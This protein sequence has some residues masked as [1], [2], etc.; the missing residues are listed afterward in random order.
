MVISFKVCWVRQCIN[1][2]FDYN[3]ELYMYQI[4]EYEV[5]C[6]VIWAIDFYAPCFQIKI[7]LTLTQNT[8]HLIQNGLDEN[9][10]N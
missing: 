9:L 2:N 1:L 4:I 8:N 7:R 6:V 3:D 5:G 10:S